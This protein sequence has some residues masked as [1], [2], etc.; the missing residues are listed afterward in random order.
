[1]EF[2][3]K[4]WDIS[5]AALVAANATPLFGVL[6]LH[7]QVFPL[8]LLYWLENVVVGLFNVLRM[9]IADPDDP[10][11]WA[12][13]L[14]MIP[15]FC[16]HYGMF[17][18]VHGVFV[19]ALFGK[20][21]FGEPFHVLANILPAI[22]RTGLGFAALSIAASHAVSFGVNYV[23]GGE[24]RHVSL[25]QLMAQPY[26][27]VIV[28]HLTILFGGF[29]MMALG[30]PVY[31]LLLLVGIKTGVDVAAHRAERR[32]LAEPPLPA[33]TIQPARVA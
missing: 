27:R 9:L 19:F 14:F 21:Q 32:K 3:P 6:F 16:V 26:T 17:T 7:W 28:L 18:F 4:R 33:K 15:F 20:S 2:H 29:L 22:Q 24:Y 23:H 1:M 30:S 11:A 31:G 13:K 5:T 10:A 12:G 25:S 8:L